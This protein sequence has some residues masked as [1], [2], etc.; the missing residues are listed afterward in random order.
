MKPKKLAN[1]DSQSEGYCNKGRSPSEF[2][3]Y[4][5]YSILQC[6]ATRAYKHSIDRKSVV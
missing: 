5:R 3:G 6:L 4:P 1:N 2:L